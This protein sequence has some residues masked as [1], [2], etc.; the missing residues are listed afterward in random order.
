MPKK[1]IGHLYTNI[2]ARTGGLEKGLKRAKAKLKGFSR[3]AGKMM[4][5][6]PI[7]G[8]MGFGATGGV[9]MGGMMYLNFLNSLDSKLDRLGKTAKM[10]GT[11]PFNLRQMEFVG[12]QA[13]IEIKALEKA[14]ISLQYAVGKA[15]QGDPLRTAIFKQLGITPDEFAKGTFIQKVLRLKEALKGMGQTRKV[16]IL[17]E[18]VEKRG[19]G[20][21]L[22]LFEQDIAASLKRYSQV[23]KGYDINKQVRGAEYREDEKTAFWTWLESTE[24]AKIPHYVR[25]ITMLLGGE[26]KAYTDWVNKTGIEFHKMVG[27]YATADWE[28][29]AQT[30]TYQRM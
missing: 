11:D 27:G 17:G 2:G 29:M 30:G 14:M 13:G 7:G 15:Q 6:T 4:S 5:K 24:A 8:M 26:E 1:T 3:S 22:Q 23:T 10:L 16:G 19:A 12:K 25:K 20:T 9:M 21:I 28:T 18:L